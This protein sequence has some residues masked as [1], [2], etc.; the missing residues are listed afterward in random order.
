MTEL[1]DLYD[2]NRQPLHKTHPRGHRLPKGTYHLAVGIWTFNYQNEI[3]ITLRA[4]EKHDWPNLWENTAGS[5]LAGETSL[6]GALRELR[7]ETGIIAAPEELHL[8]GSECGRSAFGDCYLLRR[9]LHR[10]DIILQPGETCD[11]RFVTL[12][13]LDQMIADGLVA[14]PVVTR[15]QKIRPAFESFLYGRA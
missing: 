15:L 7:E 4:P 6:E 2:Q 1:W 14:T 10:E 8:I 9:D 11:A 3:L 5:V 12:T 13:T